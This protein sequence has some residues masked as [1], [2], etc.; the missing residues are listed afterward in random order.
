MPQTP[1]WWQASNGRWYPPVPPPPPPLPPP[2]VARTAPAPAGPVL[3]APDR[4][5]PSQG[6]KDANGSMALGFFG[7]FFGW[8][9]LFGVVPAAVGPVAVYLGVRALR[10]AGAEP[11]ATARRLQGTA[12]TG[13]VLGAIATGFLVLWTAAFVWSFAGGQDPFRG[14]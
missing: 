1:E 11:P 6:M 5:R 7:V 3:L 4:P 14:L 8:L 12:T 9:P 13:I 2:P 10:A